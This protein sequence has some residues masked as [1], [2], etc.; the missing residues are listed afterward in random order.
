MRTILSTT[1]LGIAAILSVGC[2]ATS[3]DTTQAPPS[4][5]GTLAGPSAA[6]PDSDGR[7]RVV[8]AFCPIMDEHP[9]A[10]GKDPYLTLSEN[11]REYR[12][13][14]IGFCCEDCPPQWDALTEAQKTEAWAKVANKKPD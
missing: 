4:S 5:A 7:V 14:K 1:L 13:R 10:R 6:T 12:G 3:K 8:N 9:V 2:Q 11:V